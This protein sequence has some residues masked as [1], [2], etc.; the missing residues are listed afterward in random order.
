MYRVRQNIKVIKNNVGMCIEPERRHETLLL[1][2]SM[3]FRGLAIK[4]CLQ[5]VV[6]TRVDPFHLPLKH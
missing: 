3:I 2:V 5:E 1:T 4:K 6:G